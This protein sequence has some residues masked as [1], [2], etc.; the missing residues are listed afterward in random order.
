[1]QHLQSVV[2]TEVSALF[3]DRDGIVIFDDRYEMLAKLDSAPAATFS[4]TPTGTDLTYL[5]G[6]LGLAPPG[7]AYRNDVVFTGTSGIAQ[8]A[9][10][11]P[12]GFPPDGLS[13]TIPCDD[14][15]WC[16][17]NAKYL[18]GWHRQTDPWPTQLTVR[19]HP[20]VA[21][22]AAFD[23]VTTLE[24]RDYV[25]VEHTPV[26]STQRTYKCFIDG[27]VHVVDFEQ[28]IWDCTL[29]FSSADRLETAWGTK[30][31]YLWIGDATRGLIGTGKIAP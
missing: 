28:N 5:V 17:A 31:D 26:G 6:S 2:E 22:A 21:A 23:V 20:G 27:I 11:I 14:D 25:T 4:D 19:L 3:V 9:S 1:L 13:R 16:A 7:S 12:A 10:N 30:N 18:L 8:R 29:R 15:S 24:L